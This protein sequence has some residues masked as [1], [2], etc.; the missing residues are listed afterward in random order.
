MRDTLNDTGVVPSPGYPYYSP[1][2]IGHAQVANPKTFFT[3][4]YSTDPNQPIELGSAVNY[5]YVRAKNLSGETKN[6]YYI[7]VY[8]ANASLFLN[9]NVWKN[10]PLKTQAGD[11][12]V[13][14]DSTAPNAIAVGNAPFLLNA[15]TSNDFCL[16]G[17]AS[18]TSTPDIPP[19]FPSYE[20]YI[21]WVRNNQNV[22]G[23][24]LYTAQNYPDR[25]YEQLMEFS[26]PEALEVPTLFQVSIKNGT[27]P[28]NST[29]GVTCA[30]LGISDSWNV[31]D[32][33][34]RTASGM[35]PANF[36]G[37]VT[38]WATL[39][40][41]SW[42][43]GVWLETIPFVGVKEGSAAAVYARRDWSHLGGAQPEILDAGRP[44]LVPIGSCA[45]V[46]STH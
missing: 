24:N 9:T 32:G 43:E 10:N 18:P 22:C 4:N 12:F 28:A 3:D 17:M 39:S 13:S 8:R 31:N 30:P 25:N 7:T 6:G 1:D 21:L 44:H 34:V 45:T 20:A 37:N 36:N 42:P 14:L 35:T 2:L 46:F 33:V 11:A 27:L 15:V 38:T 41:G 5:F 40:S 26:N 29:F 19:N 23:R 16:I